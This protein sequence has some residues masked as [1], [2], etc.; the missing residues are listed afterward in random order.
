MDANEFD[1]MTRRVSIRFS[2]RTLSGL[3]GVSLAGVAGLTEAKKK[4]KKKIKRNGFGCVN[5]G[6]SCKNDGQCCSGICAGKKRKRKCRAHD[7]GTCQ[8]GQDSCV[9]TSVAC[10]TTGGLMGQCAVTTG[11]AE[12][13]TSSGVC[14]PCTRDSDCV[15]NFGPGAACFVCMKECA[16]SNPGGTACGG[17]TPLVV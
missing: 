5:V 16:G 4:K 7:E 6:N 13:C 10:T 17:L 3:L 9:G 11:K 8:P 12:Y 2:R 15:P 1:R 14:F